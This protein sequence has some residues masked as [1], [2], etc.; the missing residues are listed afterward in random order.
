V[1]YV[2][3]LEQNG[4]FPRFGHRIAKALKGLV[5]EVGTPRDFGTCS[6]TRPGFV[7]N[8]QVLQRHRQGQRFFPTASGVEEGNTSKRFCYEIHKTRAI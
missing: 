1:I 5:R 4:G 6:L 3:A 8:T 7:A 2:I